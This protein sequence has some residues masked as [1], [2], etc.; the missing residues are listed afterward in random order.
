MSMLHAAIDWL[1]AKPPGVAWVLAFMFS[2]VL[3]G[4]IAIFIVWLSNP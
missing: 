1:E 3:W 2:A 4:G